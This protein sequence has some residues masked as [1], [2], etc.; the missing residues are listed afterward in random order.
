MD[1][2]DTRRL[3]RMVRSG[4][5]LF[6]IFL[7]LRPAL[8]LGLRVANGLGQHLAKFGLRLRRSARCFLPCGHGQYVGR[9]REN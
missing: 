2:N 5:K 8:W 3:G 9:G 4:N 6:A 1:Q 7:G